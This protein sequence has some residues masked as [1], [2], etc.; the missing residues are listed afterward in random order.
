V[1]CGGLP[2]SHLVAL[3]ALGILA[4]ALP[5]AAPIAL[6]TGATLILVATALWESRRKA[7]DEAPIEI[8]GSVNSD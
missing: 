3:A 5:L 4:L 6:T 1:F 2:L 7:A 8:S